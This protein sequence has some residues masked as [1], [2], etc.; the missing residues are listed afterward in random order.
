MM[1]NTTK[2]VLILG[3]N[4]LIAQEFARSY[5]K[6]H[7]VNFFLISRSAK[8]LET[9]QKDL[10]ARGAGKVETSALDLNK[11][12]EHQQVFDQVKDK[13]G[14][15]D[16]VVCANGTLP[17]QE[18]CEKDFE[19]IFQEFKSNCLS[20]ISFLTLV[21]NYFKQKRSGSIAVITSVA[22]DRGRSSNYIYGSA[23]AG[24]QVFCD[25]LRNQLF[26]HNVHVCTVRP[27]FTSTPMTAH[28]KQGPLFVSAAVVGKLM[29]KAIDK[30]KNNVYTPWFWWAIMFIIRN[31]PEF[32]FKRL[33]L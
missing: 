31:I 25:G 4:S 3:A 15:I 11:F 2:N 28:L 1:N 32:V 23:K 6:N 17:D 26:H 22:A 7:S 18:K 10:L 14:E 21:S 24:L 16:L 29:V 9:T 19:L 33:K 12:K 5:I 13:L 27:G 8:K 20:I 30:K